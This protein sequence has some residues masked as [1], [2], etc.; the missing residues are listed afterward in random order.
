MSKIDLEIETVRAIQI[1]MMHAKGP[2]ERGQHAKMNGCLE[3]RFRV[4]AELPDALKVGLFEEASTYEAVI[5]YSGGAGTD[6]RIP[7]IHGMALK[8]LGVEG[9][10]VLDEAPAVDEHDFILADN[11]VFFI[12]TAADY[13][14]F[15]KDLAESAPLGKPPEKFIAYLKENHPEDIAVLLGFRQHL[16]ESPLASSYWSQVPYGFGGE[17]GAVCRYRARPATGARDGEAGDTP[18]YLRE[19]TVERLGAG[20]DEVVFDFEVQVRYGADKSII[21]NP[22]VAW[23]EPFVTVASIHIPPQTFDTAARDRYGESLSFSPWHALE[24]HRPV[25]EVNEIRKAVYLASQQLR[26][27]VAGDGPD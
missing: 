9:K 25:G 14:L 5:R 22:T 23:E 6:D 24:E 20:N 15:M 11:P 17:E 7:D 26:H 8:L 21:D 10:K 12:R 13:V 18:D 3:A 1:A 27:S 19:R 16:Q 4:H 2:H